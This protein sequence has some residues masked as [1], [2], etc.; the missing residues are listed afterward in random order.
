MLAEILQPTIG[1]S[2]TKASK[3]DGLCPDSWQRRAGK[4]GQC[5]GKYLPHCLC[6][7]RHTPGRVWGGGE[8][9][10]GRGGGGCIVY[11]HATLQKVQ[12]SGV[13]VCVCKMGCVCVWGVRGYCVPPYNITT[14]TAFWGGSLC[15]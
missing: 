11:R 5:L 15:V 9:V 13:G 4:A 6:I 14:G 3:I 2:L 7:L 10:G 8:G 12:L 1:L